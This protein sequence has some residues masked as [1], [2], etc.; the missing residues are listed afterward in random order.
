MSLAILA[1]VTLPS[2][3]TG[4]QLRSWLLSAKRVVAYE[5]GRH[6]RDGSPSFGASNVEFWVDGAVPVCAVVGQV[7]PLLSQQDTRLHE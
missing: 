3:E 4:R 7:A 2:L 6:C 5:T 1:I